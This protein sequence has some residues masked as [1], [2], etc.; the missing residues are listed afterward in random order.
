MKT[1][2]EASEQRYIFPT[3]RVN[4]EKKPLDLG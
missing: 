2:G 4:C 1:F 3:D